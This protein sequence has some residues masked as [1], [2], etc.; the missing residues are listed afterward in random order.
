MLLLQI[1]F[2]RF[3]KAFFLD[4]SSQRDCEVNTS[5]SSSQWLSFVR[6]AKRF[7]PWTRCYFQEKLCG[8]QKAAKV[9]KLSQLAGKTAMRSI[10]SP[11]QT[12]QLFLNNNGLTCMETCHSSKRRHPSWPSVSTTIAKGSGRGQEGERWRRWSACKQGGVGDNKGSGQT[13]RGGE[14]RNEKG[15]I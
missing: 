7:G 10:N 5:L 11:A 9:E 6:S 12:L 8:F 2:K 15:V 1:V 13:G 14:R 3:I 4:P